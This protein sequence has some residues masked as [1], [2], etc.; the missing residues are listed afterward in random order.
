MV[1]VS[2][3]VLYS[4]SGGGGCYYGVGHFGGDNNDPCF[5]VESSQYAL[6]DFFD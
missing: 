6:M 5:S 3:Q 4:Y 2:F 1:Y